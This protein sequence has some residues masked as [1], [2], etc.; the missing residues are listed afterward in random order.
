MPSIFTWVSK[1]PL[2]HSECAV[3]YLDSVK[4]E[5]VKTIAWSYARLG[6]RENYPL[7]IDPARA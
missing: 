4:L 2:G 1:G 3:E 6:L 7:E 5:Q